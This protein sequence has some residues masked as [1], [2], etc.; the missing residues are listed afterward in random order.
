M[1]FV[2]EI[3]R[4]ANK[5]KAHMNKIVAVTFAEK[6]KTILNV[7]FG[8]PAVILAFSARHLLTILFI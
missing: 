3:L 4:T 8:T 5:L 7:P 2:A 1:L 6:A